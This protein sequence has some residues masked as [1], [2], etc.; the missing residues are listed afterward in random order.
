MRRVAASKRPTAT[1]SQGVEEAR[2]KLASMTL[3][4]IPP[5]KKPQEKPSSKLSAKAAS[6]N[7]QAASFRLEL[8]LARRRHRS[9]PRQSYRSLARV[10]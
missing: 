4:A 5:F 8:K 3:P 10:N 9:R 6:F 1:P 7:P 2:A